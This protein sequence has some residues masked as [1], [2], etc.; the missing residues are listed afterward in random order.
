MKDKALKIEVNDKVKVT[1][2]FGVAKKWILNKIKKAFSLIVDNL[3]F[4]FSIVLNWRPA[5][6]RAIPVG[7][8]SVSQLQ[9]AL[10]RRS[11]IL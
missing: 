2:V 5:L 3:A 8:L 10:I 7:L 6:A 11:F 1:D 9:T 4:S